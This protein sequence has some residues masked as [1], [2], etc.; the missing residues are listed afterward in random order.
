VN[1]NWYRPH[2]NSNTFVLRDARSTGVRQ[3][4][5]ATLGKPY[6]T[7]KLNGF[8]TLYLYSYDVASRFVGAIPAA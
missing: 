2:P 6:A 4:L 8:I 3:E 7:Y 1:T 5:P